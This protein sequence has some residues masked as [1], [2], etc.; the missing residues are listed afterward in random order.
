MQFW[1]LFLHLHLPETP[2]K[3]WKDGKK[4]TEPGVP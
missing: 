4:P 2:E 3:S 1:P